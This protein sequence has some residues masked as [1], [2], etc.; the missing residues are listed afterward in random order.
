M[1]DDII[2]MEIPETNTLETTGGIMVLNWG[3]TKQGNRRLIT[4]VLQVHMALMDMAPIDTALKIIAKISEAEAL[5][6]T[7]VDMM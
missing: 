3:T 4:S 6:T 1:K 7:A 5:T 2:T